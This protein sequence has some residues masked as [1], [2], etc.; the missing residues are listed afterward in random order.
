[1]VASI[2]EA[3]LRFYERKKNMKAFNDDQWLSDNGSAYV[4]H[5]TQTFTRMMDTEAC[6]RLITVRSL[7][8]WR[9][10]MMCCGKR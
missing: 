8:E 2:Y 5:D 9:N 3:S 6:M 10:G 1:M 4:D 7:T